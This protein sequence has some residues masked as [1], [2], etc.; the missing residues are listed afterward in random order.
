MINMPEKIGYI[1]FVDGTY[2]VTENSPE[3]PPGTTYIRADLVE[4]HVTVTPLATPETAD[5]RT[6]SDLLHSGRTQTLADE[7]AAL[8]ALK[9]T[10]QKSI[11]GGFKCI[12]PSIAINVLEL[13][14][15]DINAGLQQSDN[16]EIDEL[17]LDIFD[18]CINNNEYAIP[19]YCSERLMK[20]L[21]NKHKAKVQG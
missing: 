21:E 19:K 18:A 4:T 20:I 7:A 10:M 5:Q 11:T 6:Q 16:G 17:L 3:I 2:E 9:T 15:L 1:K 14:W 13:F 12:S 8:D